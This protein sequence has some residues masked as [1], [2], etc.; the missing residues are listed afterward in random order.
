MFKCMNTEK[1]YIRHKNRAL[2][3][4]LIPHTFPGAVTMFCL[5]ETLSRLSVSLQ[6]RKMLILTALRFSLRSAAERETELRSV[7]RETARL[8]TTGRNKQLLKQ[9]DQDNHFKQY[10]T[11]V[12]CKILTQPECLK[13]TFLRL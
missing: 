10:I 5:Q 2:A 3:E 4:P 12:T 9:E 6:S 1:N 7:G 13:N 11:A 8:L